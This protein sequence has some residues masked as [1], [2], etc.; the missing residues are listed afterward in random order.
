MNWDDIRI[1]L[2][3]ADAQSLGGAVRL[4]NASPATLSRR[5]ARLEQALGQKLFIHRST[6]YVLNEDGKSFLKEARAFGTAEQLVARWRSLHDRPPV[7]R[8]SAGLW[9]SWLLAHHLDRLQRS[10]DSF[11]LAFLPTQSAV[12]IGRDEADIGIRNHRPDHVWLAGQ[13]MGQVHFAAFSAKGT[14]VDGWIAVNTPESD[15]ELRTPSQIW[16]EKHVQQQVILSVSDPRTALDM[17]LANAGKLVLPTF[18][19]DRI[20]ALRRVGGTIDELSHDQWLVSHHDRRH[21]TSTRTMLGRIKQ[22]LMELT[23]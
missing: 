1:F 19:G 15:T 4:A 16:I 17:A 2:A 13:K 21:D 5:I 10:E 23:V 20:D 9:T 22:L 3:V 18:V 12:D 14:Q 11:Q 6:G 7:V 8:I